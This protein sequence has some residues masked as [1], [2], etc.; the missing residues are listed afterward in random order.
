M[1]NLKHTFD[2]SFWL[3]QKTVDQIVHLLDH[4][5][6]VIREENVGK[7]CVL[8]VQELELILN[9]LYYLFTWAMPMNLCPLL[10]SWNLT[11]KFEFVRKGMNSTAKTWCPDWNFCWFSPFCRGCSID[12][13][14]GGGGGGERTTSLSLQ[15]HLCSLRFWFCKMVKNK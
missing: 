11:C 2:F 5:I 6:G 4:W 12:C 15:Y 13:P 1:E 3:L 14:V 7:I 9:N 10:P 8:F